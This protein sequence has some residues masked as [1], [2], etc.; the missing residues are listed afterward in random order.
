[1]AW[2]SD[3]Q[4][5]IAFLTLFALELVLGIDNI[6]FITILAEKVPEGE[7]KKI[8]RIGLFLAMFMR[9]GLLFSLSFI[10]KL[11]NPLFAVF[12]HGV[13]GRDLILIIGGLFL[14]AKSTF[15]IHHK[16]EGVEGEAST[17]APSSV[18]GILLQILLLDLVFSLDSVITAVGMV[19]NLQV[20]VAAVV[21]SVA[22]MM[23]FANPVGAFVSKHPTVKM[24]ALSFLILIGAT[25]VMEGFGSHVEKAYVYFAIAFSVFVEML[26][27]K[28]R[29]G[30]K[31]EP[32]HLHERYTAEEPAAKK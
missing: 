1:M 7:R 8:V 19:N 10:V 29:K 27:M 17:K 14:L 30:P 25:L 2:M 3:P 11:T 20:M 5:W 24:L 13:S 32:V 22:A 26:N 16:L 21:A 9:I 31:V 12:G 6:I 28:L 15:E 23:F 18:V 4:L